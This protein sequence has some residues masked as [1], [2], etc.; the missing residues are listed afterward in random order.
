MKRLARQSNKP[1]LIK[2]VSPEKTKRIG[3]V[4]LQELNPNAPN[5]KRKKGKGQLRENLNEDKTKVGGDSSTA[6]PS[7][8]SIL[9]WNGRGF[10]T[11]LTVRTLT[12]EVKGKNPPFWCSW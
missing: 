10:G 9:A 6:S 3:P 8:I 7:L 12:K 4:P 11:P 2:K 1:S 5:T